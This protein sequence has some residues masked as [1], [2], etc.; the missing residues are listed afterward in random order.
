[1]LATS[2]LELPHWSPPCRP[3][4]SNV[5]E[6]LPF[7]LPRR[8]LRLPRTNTLPR[9]HASILNS[10]VSPHSSSTQR[11]LLCSLPPTCNHRPTPI[12]NTKELEFHYAKCH[13]H[14]CEIMGCGCVFPD[15]RL[16]E[17]V[18]SASILCF[19][20][21]LKVFFFNIALL[22]ILDL[23]YHVQHQTE[24]QDPLATVQKERG[25]KIVSLSLSS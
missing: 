22:S 18:C 24:C 7:H 6:H 8:H 21:S 5:T 25:E 19:L 17:L 10:R 1:V 23:P 3:L 12:A 11:P 15:A 14:V 20:C 13:A 16:L 2:P 9:H 4:H